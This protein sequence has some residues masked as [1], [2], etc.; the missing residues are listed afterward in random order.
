MAAETLDATAEGRRRS[1]GGEEGVTSSAWQRVVL[2]AMEQISKSVTSLEE[3]QVG[4][5]VFVVKLWP[6]GS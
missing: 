5:L 3:K 4:M 1:E 6:T 2:V